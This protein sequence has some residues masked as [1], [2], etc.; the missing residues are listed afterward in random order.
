V[1]YRL[2][3][4]CSGVGGAELSFGGVAESVFAAEIADFPRAVFRRRFPETPLHGDFVPFI[5]DA[6]E[7]DILAGGTPCQSFSVSGNRLS[8]DDARGNLT[9]AYVKLFDAVDHKNKLAG[10]RPAVCL[11]ENVPGVLN[12]K[13]N[14]FGCFLAAL[15]GWPTPL[16][17]GVDSNKWSASGVAVGPKRT[18]A[19][20]V[21]DAQY[22][23]LAQRRRRVFVIASAREGF[24]PAAVLFESAGVR[25]HYTQGKNARENLA[26]TIS[27]RPSGGGGLGTDADLDGG[28]VVA[29]V[30]Y[31]TSPNCGAGATGDHVDALTTGT[32]PSSHLLAFGGN[33][34]S[35]AIDVATACNAHSG[36]HGRLDFESETF[37]THALRGDGFD[38][39]EDGTGRGT[40]IIAAY[41]I[42][43]GAEA[44]SEVQAVAFQN[45]T[46]VRRLTPRECERLQG[47]PDDFTVLPTKRSE[48]PDG[49]RYKAVGN[50]WAINNVRWIALRLVAELERGETLQTRLADNT[51]ARQRYTAA[52]LTY[53]EAENGSL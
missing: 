50:G 33:N 9:L 40:P 36:P 46:G 25:G 39:S 5:E 13:D 4:V 19:W 1:T 32:D 20:R 10:K 3:S 41:A 28:L 45:R 47:L 7:L 15:V 48:P 31:R 17:A 21:F 14:A 24:D 30:A 38:A 16:L 51:A 53:L 8:L 35:G 43:A 37:I 18:A 23:G 44:R 34:T 42:Q 11:W 26:P 27:S 49:P 6:P 12:T 2:G 22:F 29:P 52:M